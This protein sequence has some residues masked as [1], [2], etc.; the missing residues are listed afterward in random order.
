MTAP[1]TPTES[2][3]S[4]LDSKRPILGVVVPCFNEEQVLPETAKRLD[5]LLGV[6][7]STGRID[8]QSRIW[9]VDD[10]SRDG[11]WALIEAYSR[12]VG[13]RIAGFKLTRNRGH[14]M[15]LL[16]GL[17]S[18]EGDVLISIDADLQDDLDAIPRMLDEYL[19]GSDIVYGVR[20]C[21]ERDSIFKRVTAEAYYRLLKALGVEI[22]FNHADFRLM[23]R[24]AVEALREHRETNLFLRGLVPQL[25]FRSSIVHYERLER[26]AGESKYPIRKMLALAWQGITSFT[27]APL[28]FI[29]G[30]GM[31]IS[32]LSLGLGAW[33]LGMR[34]FT[35][36]AVPGWASIVVPLFLLS[37]V[38]LLA[39]GVIGEYLAKIYVE[40]KQRPRYFIEQKQFPDTDVPR[41]DHP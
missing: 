21:R 26:F 13:S 20:S 40:V 9:F 27:A 32:V 18:A 35:D 39:L 10:G 5:A 11:T 37:G 14:Q 16:A 6:L 22:V 17:L 19:A 7:V 33:A 38:Q 36:K 28:R 25:G 4:P 34:V 3:S 12:T 24:R 30:L 41:P 8:G 23:S 29:T 1:R 15:A 2:A 31:S